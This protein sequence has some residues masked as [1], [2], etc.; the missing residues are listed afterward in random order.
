M[1]R[2][3]D[4]T[5]N[6]QRLGSPWNPD[7]GIEGLFV[8]VTECQALATEGAEPIT[9][10]EV[11]RVLLEVIDATGAFI[12]D[13]KAW[14]RVKLAEQKWGYFQTFFTDAASERNKRMLEAAAGVTAGSAGYHG[15]HAAVPAPSTRSDKPIYSYCWTHGKLLNLQHTS[16]TCK[17]KAAGHQDAASLDNMMGGCT[18]IYRSGRQRR[19]RDA[20]QA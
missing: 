4:L 15:A 8:R 6:R 14:R 1:V 11:Q 16:H 18:T 9:Q 10:T 13:V 20:Q 3:F 5:T 2:D 19:E 17:T 7:D 12:D